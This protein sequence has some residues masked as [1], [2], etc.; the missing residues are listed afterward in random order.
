MARQFNLIV[1][2]ICVDLEYIHDIALIT[3]INFH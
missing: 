2:I 3:A 1:F